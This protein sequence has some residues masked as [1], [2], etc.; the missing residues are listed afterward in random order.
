MEASRQF[1]KQVPKNL[2]V[3]VLSFLST[4]IIGLW[5]TPYLLKH[6]GLVAYGLI[7]LAMFFSQYVS[8]II[9]AINMSI[10]RFLLI[11]L[12]KHQDRDAN[13]IFNTSIGV[14]FTFI[15]FQVVIM[16]AVL[17]DITYF[18]S[19]PKELVNDAT[20]LFGLTFLGFSISLFRSVF[21]TSMFAYNRL[22]ILRMID[23]IQNLVRVV[24]IVFFFAYDEPSLKYIGIANL[25]A[26]VSAV[27]PTLYFFREYTP[28]LK[29]KIS[30]F[31][32][33]RVAELAQMSTW[34]LINQVGVLLLG[35]IDLYLINK[36]LGLKATGEY[37]I[38]LQFTSIFRTFFTLVASILTPVIMIYFA[39][40]EFEKL[41]QF[42]LLS[43]KVM[44]LVFVLPLAMVIGLSENIIHFWLG[45]QYSY[46]HDMV[47]FSMLFFI[48][49]IP[50]STLFTIT[51]S[52]NKV[53][54]PAIIS[55]ILG[56]VSIVSLYML[57]TEAGL[58]LWSVLL[59]K[60]IIEIVFALFLVIYVARI[61][62]MNRWKF[63]K[64]LGM[65]VGYFMFI[66]AIIYSFKRYLIMDDWFN[67][68]VFCIGISLLV[69]S[70]ASFILLSKEERSLIYK[71]IILKRK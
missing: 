54:L 59:V 13:E 27:L 8:V 10:N 40:D 39:N 11:A 71:K 57:M 34:V 4:I 3:N 62:N 2:V 21:A 19:I 61:L 49:A 69:Y 42:T 41:K 35:N 53:K 68:G 28:Q 56:G 37:A 47:S 5:L 63:L 60:L 36:W 33:H 9:N 6:L 17:S 64:I 58:G 46:L 1:H 65:S 30:S 55:L 15:I 7:P 67:L 43:S 25:L 26:A 20:W 66:M 50:M 12:Q 44:I 23:I 14:I 45:K 16:G 70:S 22:D 32:R 24:I 29:V 51:L 31:S 52:Y 38:I 18:F 48:I